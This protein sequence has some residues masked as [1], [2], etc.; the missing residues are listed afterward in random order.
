[1]HTIT[2]KM[3]IFWRSGINSFTL[4]YSLWEKCIWYKN[5]LVLNLPTGA[6]NDEY[7]STIV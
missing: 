3:W 5:V 7:K 6:N 1:M 4:H 2:Y